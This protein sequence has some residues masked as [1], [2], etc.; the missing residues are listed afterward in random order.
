MDVKQLVTKLSNYYWSPAHP[1]SYVINLPDGRVK[2]IGLVASGN[3]AAF[4]LAWAA[5]RGKWASTDSNL[6]IIHEYMKYKPYTSLKMGPQ[7]LG[8]W[9]LMQTPKEFLN[10]LRLTPPEG[11]AASVT[12]IVYGFTTFKDSTAEKL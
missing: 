1:S 11:V 6:A 5:V 3:Y 2:G 10:Q 9:V 7:T 12:R 4:N 8:D